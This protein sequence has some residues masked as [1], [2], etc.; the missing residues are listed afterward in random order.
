MKG[1]LTSR[2]PVVFWFLA[3][4]LFFEIVCTLKQ[5]QLHSDDKEAAVTQAEF[6]IRVAVL[7]DAEERWKT[8]VENEVTEMSA[9]MAEEVVC[10]KNRHQGSAASTVSWSTGNS[11]NVGNF[12]SRLRQ[13][14]FVASRIELKGWVVGATFAGP[15]SEYGEGTP[16]AG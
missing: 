6:R 16:E 8:R 7:K 12:A 11:G 2:A 3:R 5:F 13:N 9:K 15:A 14:T 10:V 4:L 1:V